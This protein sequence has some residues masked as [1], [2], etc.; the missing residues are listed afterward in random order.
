MPPLNAL[1]R[2]SFLRQGALLTG[3]TLL[4]GALSSLATRTSAG[5]SVAGPS[6][7]GALAPAIDRNTGLPLLLLPAG[8]TYTTLNWTGDPMDNGQPTPERFDG[9]AVF[10]A[11]NG[12]LRLVRNHES[13]SGAGSFAPA[14]ST[15]DDAAG[16][17]TT[18]LELDPVRGRLERV[19]PSLS[20]TLLNCAGG[21]TPWRSWLTCEENVFDSGAGDF[22][23]P[24]GYVFE[25]PALGMG[26][27]LPLTALGRFKHEAACVDPATG[28]V[29][30]TEDENASGFYRFLPARAGDLAAGGTLQML[31]VNGAPAY[32]TRKDQTVGAPLGTAWV[33]IDEPNPAIAV[34]PT[35]VFGE[36]KAKGGAIF[37]RG[38]GIF[39]GNGRVYFTCTSG[40]NAGQGQL[41][42]YDPISGRLE[43]LYESPGAAEMSNPDNIAVSPR[44]TVAICED[45]SGTT[46]MHAFTRAGQLFTFA[47]SNV[48]LQG[49]KNGVVGDYSGDEFC[50]VT[51]DPFG[52]WMFWNVQTPGITFAVTGPWGRGGL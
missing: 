10:R 46:R 5:A 3:G 49:E 47:Q 22:L 21:A 52:K 38:E 41:W 19:F 50:G 51:F 34:A 37:A 4:G 16:G 33:T 36:G 42:A 27:P 6:P 29:Y 1:S 2:R 30:E 40:G 28:I 24:H 14:S 35:R 7:Y 43:L 20:G 8:F 9:M 32:D 48:V 44:G 26:S 25:V 17:G 15:Y 31:A 45:G 12:R 23:K 11:P 18:T 13:L 39:F